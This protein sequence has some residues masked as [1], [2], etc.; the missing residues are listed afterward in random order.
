M[1]IVLD[2]NF[3]IDMV[4]FKTDLDEI[5]T[6]I[7]GQ[8]ELVTLD[9]VVNELKEIAKTRSRESSYAKVALELIKNKQIKILRTGGK[10]DE[11]MLSL[12]K[13]VVA[14]NDRKLRKMLKTKGA[15]TI[16]IKSRKHLGI[17]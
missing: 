13:A 3:L 1:Q 15:K 6:L 5:S 7:L 17:D 8:Y 4:R 2:T 12:D 11:A 14:T 9:A 16:Y 10:T